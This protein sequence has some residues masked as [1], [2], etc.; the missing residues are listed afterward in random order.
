MQ[1]NWLNLSNSTLICYWQPSAWPL[2]SSIPIGLLLRSL[3]FNGDGQFLYFQ[4]EKYYFNWYFSCF[5]WNLNWPIAIMAYSERRMTN[6]IWN[7][8]LFADLLQF[9]GKRNLIMN[10]ILIFLL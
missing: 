9:N 1:R 10:E 2:N 5:S 7:E 8:F 3:G 6:K 4:I